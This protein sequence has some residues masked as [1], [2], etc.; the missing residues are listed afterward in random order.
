MSFV[1]RMRAKAVSLQRTLVLPE[2]TEPR[3]VR[4]ARAIVDQKLAKT[5]TLLGKMDAVHAVAKAEGV[6]LEGVAVVD[7]AVAPTRDQFAQEYY[8][9]RK[10]KGM[11][12]EQAAAD[13]VEPLR[14][15]AMMVRTGEA[16]A[17]VAGAENSTGNVLLAAFNIIKTAPGTKY[18]SSCFVM[19][20]PDSKWGVDGCMIF[21]GLRHDSGSECGTACR[22][23]HCRGAELSQ[24]F[25]RRTRC[26]DVVLLNQGFGGAPGGRQGDGRAGDG[27]RQ[28]ASTAGGRRVTVGRGDRAERRFKEGSRFHGGG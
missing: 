18:A 20:M 14:W 27:T 23:R 4:A 17:M 19:Q 7:P 26:S 16:H 11:S 28:S 10:H 15:G 8:E 25:G 3:T 2:G 12:I 6:S 24:L 22:N 13:I 9:L 5:V 1:E 21:F